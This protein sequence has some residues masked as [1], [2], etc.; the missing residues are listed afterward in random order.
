MQAR[1]GRYFQMRRWDRQNGGE[2]AADCSFVRVCG[3][4]DDPRLARM[5]Q[6][7]TEDQLASAD[8]PRPARRTLDP[9]S[10]AILDRR[11]GNFW[12]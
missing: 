10:E 6:D 11:S 5:M 3:A 2:M 12:E 7:Y 9:D 4:S 1:R 8:R